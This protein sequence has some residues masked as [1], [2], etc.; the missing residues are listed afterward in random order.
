MS[1]VSRRVEWAGIDGIRRKRNPGRIGPD[2]FFA[3]PEAVRAAFG[4]LIGAEDRGRIAILPSASYGLAVAARNTPIAA[5]GNVVIAAEQFPSNV[6]IWK[7][8]CAEAGAEL[9]IV[10]APDASSRGPAWNTALLDAIDGST[11]AVAM[12]QVHWTDG[13]RFDL[14]AIGIRAREVG[15]A[16]I[17]DGAQSVGA[18]PFDL[19]RIRPDALVCVGYKWL[20][21]PYGVAVGWYGER[22]DAGVPLEETWLARTGSE[23]FRGLVDYEDEYRPGA[24]RY[25][26]GES[27]NFILMPMMAAALEQVLGWGVDSIAEHCAALLEPLAAEARERGWQVEASAD[28]APHILGVRLPADLDIEGLKGALDRR[29]VVASLRGAALRVSPHVYNDR[30]DVEALRDALREVA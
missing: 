6:Y 15:A 4:R 27:S 16:F 1:P 29:S 5:G 21:G 22:Y 24:A 26:V 23:D 28:R 30:R 12:G 17:V 25:D 8:L 11:A 20:M 14:E 2:D 13:T 18:M 19:G 7:R 10:A 9:R 3:G